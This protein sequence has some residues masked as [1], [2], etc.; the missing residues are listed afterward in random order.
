MPQRCVGHERPRPTTLLIEKFDFPTLP[1]GDHHQIGL[2]KP[3]RNVALFGWR[4]LFQRPA[5]F[6]P[7]PHVINGDR[8]QHHTLKPQPKVCKTSAET[9]WEGTRETKKNANRIWETYLEVGRQRKGKEEQSRPHPGN[10]SSE[11]FSTT[12]SPTQA[13][14]ANAF[15]TQLAHWGVGDGFQKMNHEILNFSIKRVDQHHALKAC[16]TRSSKNEQLR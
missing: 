7:L 3:T 15:K 10:A 11:H 4:Q 8:I 6:L 5:S 12:S 16:W 13:L 14:P 9:R 2:N 1:F